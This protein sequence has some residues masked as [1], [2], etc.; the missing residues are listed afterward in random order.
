SAGD[1]NR[2]AVATC[3][4][5]LSRASSRVTDPGQDQTGES[6]MRRH[7]TIAVPWAILLLVAGCSSPS[8]RFYSLSAAPP[9][10]VAP[11]DLSLLV[12][13]VVIP[14]SVDRAQM[15]V[16]VGQ[17]Q[18]RVDEFNRW[19]GPLQNGIARVVAENLVAMLGTPRVTVTS[20]TLT[21]PDYRVAI[22]VQR[23]DSALGE[24]ATVGAV[25]SVLRIEGGRAP[26]GRT[27]LREST[28]AA[29]HGAVVAA[30]SR[31]LARLSQDIAGA[32]Q[33]L[34]RAGG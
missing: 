19:V 32:V 2:C 25:L 15:V 18:V 28:T 17:N 13:P 14:A 26:D 23:F 8:S 1:H 29:R 16:S 24:A 10:A 9:P 11:S 31:A 5:G 6:V 3:L 30:H 21:I 7:A 22:D 34:N 27:S 12:H 20:Q 4:N 33:A